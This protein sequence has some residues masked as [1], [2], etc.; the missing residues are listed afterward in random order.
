MLM[1]YMIYFM[2][3]CVGLSIY[4]CEPGAFKSQKRMLDPLELESQVIVSH[5]GARN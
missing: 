5:V 3:V 1:F 4:V 2:Y